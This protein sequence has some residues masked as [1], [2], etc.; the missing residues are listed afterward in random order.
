MI[1]V[2][3]RPRRLAIYR[4]PS[5][6]LLGASWSHVPGWSTRK[7]HLYLGWWVLTITTRAAAEHKPRAAMMTEPSDAESKVLGL[8]Q[9]LEDA[10]EK[11]K[12]KVSPIRQRSANGVPK[13]GTSI[14]RR[15]VE[16]GASFIGLAPGKTHERGI[17]DDWQWFCSVECYA[18]KHPDEAANLV[19]VVGGDDV[20]GEGDG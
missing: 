17:W 19:A 1:P 9:A 8:M 6:L 15:C 10:V 11:A 13:P 16:C 20:K 5:C 14:E 7:T 12:V 3:T 2:E 4:N 18:V